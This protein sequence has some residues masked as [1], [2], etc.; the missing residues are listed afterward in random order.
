MASYVTPLRATEFIF[1]VGLPSQA[2]TK[3]F[4]ANPTL[5]AGD[6]K[7]SIDGGA[8]NNLNTLPA[9]TPAA[10]KLVKVTV[11]AAEMTGDNLQIIFSDA[12]GA[13]WCDL[14][15]NIQTTTRQIDNLSFPNTSGRGQDVTATGAV[16]IDWANVENPTT[17]L[18]LSGTTILDVTDVEAAIADVLSA[19]AA[20]NNL[21]QG[22]VVSAVE[23]LLDLEIDD[24]VAAEGDRPS[25]NQALLMITRM[26]M[27]KSLSGT[28][29][30]VNKEDGTTASM[31]FTL[32]DSTAPT[33]ISRAS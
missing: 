9:V 17:V 23:T 2:D 11:S 8:L 32:N 10:G 26:M 28:T 27:E 15:I 1:Y 14:V 3:L 18:N 25:I 12:A 21:S 30:T 24:S 33:S 4:Q 29:M 20:L 31:T 22:E 19:I 13:E 5:A 16:G 6:V 7:V